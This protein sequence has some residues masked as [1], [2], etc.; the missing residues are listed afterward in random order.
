MVARAV[1]VVITIAIAVTVSV[2]TTASLGPVQDQGHVLYFFIVDLLQFR[3]HAPFE[4][5]CADY[6][7][8][9]SASFS[10]ICVSATSSTGGQSI[11]T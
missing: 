10:I 1:T 3:E 9:R 11:S 7:M 4:Q 2:S 6:E 5:P 8:V